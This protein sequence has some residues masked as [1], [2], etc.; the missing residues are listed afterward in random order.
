M[1]QDEKQLDQLIKKVMTYDTPEAAP[2]DFT[3]KVMAQLQPVKT[4]A[5]TTHKPLIPTIAWIV[6][7]VLFVGVATWIM[8]N[9]DATKGGYLQ[10]F[11]AGTDLPLQ[12]NFN[13]S[14]TLFYA[15]LGLVAMLGVQIFILKDYFEKR[16]AV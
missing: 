15:V 9:A 3:S 14:K 12:W 10:Q 5:V 1:E 7:G 4:S 11:M 8:F 16:L 6:I 2:A 13:G